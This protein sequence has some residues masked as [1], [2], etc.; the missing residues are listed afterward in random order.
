MT[1]VKVQNEHANQVAA[2]KDNFKSDFT[3]FNRSAIVKDDSSVEDTNNAI[4]MDKL[5]MKPRACKSLLANAMSV[6]GLSKD[7]NNE[8]V[9]GDCQILVL[10]LAYFG[11]KR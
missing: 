4:K 11:P 9:L 8:D 10:C 6:L 5:I 7:E 2:K 1:V 3:K